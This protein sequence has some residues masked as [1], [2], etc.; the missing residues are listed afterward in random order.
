MPS[1]KNDGTYVMSVRRPNRTPAYIYI[2]IGYTDRASQ[3]V[4][5]TVL[6]VPKLQAL[7]YD[8]LPPTTAVTDYAIVI[9]NLSANRQFFVGAQMAVS[10]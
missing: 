2:Y 10:L 1:S 8:I 3:S 7:V 6:T 9:E 4:S 5:K